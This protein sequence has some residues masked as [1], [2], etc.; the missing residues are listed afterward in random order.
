[1]LDAYLLKIAGGDGGAKITGKPPR[2]AR[3]VWYGV[4]TV[5]G[6]KCWS[7]RYAYVVLS[8]TSENPNLVKADHVPLPVNESRGAQ[9]ATFRSDVLALL[10]KLGA[11]KAVFKIAENISNSDTDRAEVEG[12]FQEA[13]FSHDPSV[14]AEGLLKLQIKKRLDFDGKA[15]DVFTMFQ[16]RKNLF[17]GLGKTKYEEAAV[18]AL[19]GLV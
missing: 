12:V 3:K 15:K 18:T 9:L 7:D 10:T 8:G 19:A 6:V 13:C 11:T 1:M 2:S 17:V 14:E 4:A 5:V 16:E